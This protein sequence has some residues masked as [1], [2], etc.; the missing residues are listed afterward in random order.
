MSLNLSPEAKVDP[1]RAVP[2]ARAQER[3]LL[4]LIRQYFVEVKRQ[5]RQQDFANAK[6]TPLEFLRFADSLARQMG[7]DD[8]AVWSKEWATATYG[9]GR[10][11]ASIVLGAPIEVRQAAWR[12]TG[13]ILQR[14]RRVF[15]KMT[16]DMSSDVRRE[17][18]SI[19]IREGSQRD[20]IRAIQEL[21]QSYEYAARRIARTETQEAVNAG[22]MDGYRAHE[23]EKVEW[24]AAEGCCPKCQ[25]LDGRVFSIDSGVHAPLHPNCRCTTIPVIDVPGMEIREAEAWAEE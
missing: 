23:V 7:L 22:V 25:A 2:I 18:S 15:Q 8:E 13:M 14:S 24:L 3:K 16:Y 17:I 12:K 1:T 6:M 21:S 20:M 4:R 10:N 9:Q 19:M 11:F 5:L